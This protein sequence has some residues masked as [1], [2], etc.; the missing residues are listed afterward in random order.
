MSYV[1]QNTVWPD[2]ARLSQ[3]TKDLISLFY[4]LADHPGPDAGPRLANEVFM[5]DARMV[6]GTG[7]FKG[8]EGEHVG[9]SRSW[10][11]ASLTLYQRYAEVGTMRGLL[12]LNAI[13]RSSK[14]TSTTNQV[15]I[16]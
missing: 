5:E 12:S 9:K 8:S 3:K 2:S 7:E 6:A 1:T 13:T 11:S 16:S 4:S 10:T 15:V 14:Y